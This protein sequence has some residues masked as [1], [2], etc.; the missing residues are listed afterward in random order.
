M[1]PKICLVTGAAR[2]IGAAIL[3]AI[4]QSGHHAIALVRKLAHVSNETYRVDVTDRGS[5][6]GAVAEVIDKHG[7]IDVLVNNAGFGMIGPIELLSDEEMDRQFD[8][9]VFG[10][11]RMTQ[12]VLPHMRAARSGLIINMSSLAGIRTDIGGGLY[13]A[14]KRAVESTT[15]SLASE[16]A[17]WN[18]KAISV[19]PGYTRTEFI[20]SVSIGTRLRKH[21]YGPLVDGYVQAATESLAQGQDPA[22]VGT[23]VAKLIDAPDPAIINPTT[24]QGQELLAEVLVDPTG[25]EQVR[26]NYEQALTLNAIGSVQ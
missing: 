26:A 12:A 22:E 11:I 19:N 25:N 8:V 18:I 21:P 2:G 7:R 17:P 24:K 9:N 4:N 3:D 6:D 10:L 15:V 5:I 23:L 14:S 1:K 13:A 16:L 20:D